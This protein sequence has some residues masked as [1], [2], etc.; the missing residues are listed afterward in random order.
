MTGVDEGGRCARVLDWGGSSPG[1]FLRDKKNFAAG[2]LSIWSRLSW[3]QLFLGAMMSFVVGIPGSGS[4]S[5]Q[6]QLQAQE[7]PTEAILAVLERATVSGELRLAEVQRECESRIATLE[8]FQSREEWERYAAQLRQKILEEIVFRGTPPE[9]RNHRVRVEWFEEI[10]AGEGYRIRKLRYE[11]LPGLWIP[12]LLYSPVQLIGRV[13]AVLNVNGHT[14]LGKQ[15]PPKQLRC[16][17]M[18]KE[19]VI[20]LNIEWVGMGQLH[21]PGY[22][23]GRMNQLDLCGVSGLAVFYLNMKAGLDV[24]LSLETVD[25]N[26]VAMTGLSGGGW[27]TIFLSALDTRVKLS[28]PV[29]GYS[30]FR[31]RVRH[32][33]D[34]GDSEQTPTDFAALADYTHLTALLAPRPALLTYNAKD[35]CCFEAGYALEPLVQAAQPIYDLYGRS[36]AFRTHINY[37]PGTH[38]YD[39]DNRQAFYRMLGDFFFGRQEVFEVSEVPAE[40]ELKSSEELSVPLPERNHDFNSLALEFAKDLPAGVEVPREPEAFRKWQEDHRQQVRA[41]IR[42]ESYDVRAYQVGEE[43]IPMATVR[44]W[45]LELGGKWTLPAAEFIPKTRGDSETCGQ[46]GKVRGVIVL[47]ENDT[48]MAQAVGQH[49][50]RGTPVLALRPIGWGPRQVYFL[51]HLFLASVGH[52]TLGL[53][54]SEVVAAAKWWSDSGK[55]PEIEIDAEGRTL[56]LMALLAAVVEPDVIASLYL[57][58]PMSSLKQVIEENWSVD[59]HPEVFCFGLLKVTDVPILI[60]AIAPRKIRIQSAEDR[61]RQAVMLG[62]ERDHVVFD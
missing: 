49:L 39:L 3:G 31:T 13:P 51:W 22:H 8:A 58:Q 56:S 2:V 9:W 26:R 60:T 25:P 50:V 1:N 37:E 57:R 16:I 44:Q 47:R 61:L 33:K 54:A 18:A 24:L 43:D 30:S 15:Y 28:C 6:S 32:A 55:I 10:P 52:R 34:L 5:P 59:Q 29:A 23:H 46:S 35:E 53:Q 27:Q 4:G 45:R 17:H 7:I 19:G 12:A 36:A 48:A 42:F 40:S 21:S 62:G 20:A 41:T 11:A 38:N 14:P